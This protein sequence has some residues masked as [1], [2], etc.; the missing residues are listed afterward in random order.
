MYSPLCLAHTI[1]I[2]RPLNILCT[3]YTFLYFETTF[4]QHFEQNSL[5]FIFLTTFPFFGTL[6]SGEIFSNAFFSWTYPTWVVKIMIIKWTCMPGL[7]LPV[8]FSTANYGKNDLW[9]KWAPKKKWR[10][11]SPS[12]AQPGSGMVARH[13]SIDYGYPTEKCKRRAVRRSIWLRSTKKL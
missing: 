9:K 12:S 8:S 1:V 10:S 3:S 6:C 13:D 2:W 5:F 4:F 7:T 11:Q